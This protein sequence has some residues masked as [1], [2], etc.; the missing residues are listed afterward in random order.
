MNND[1][2]LI[3]EADLAL[4]QNICNDISDDTLRNK[5]VANVLAAKIAKKYFTEYDI[6]TESGLHNITQISK[7]IEISDIYLDDAYI[8]VRIYFENEIPKVPKSHFEQD[9]LPNA[10]MF[11][12]VDSE[13]SNATVTGFI[14]PDSIDTT[15]E[16]NEYYN[17][18]EDLLVSFYDIQGSINN[19]DVDVLDD[20]EIDIF[21]FLDNK[22]NETEEFFRNLTKSK[23][24]RIYLKDAANA[25]KILQQI[26]ISSAIETMPNVEVISENNT[27]S[28][29]ESDDIINLDNTFSDSFDSLEK[30]Q[31]TDLNFSTDIE[32]LEETLDSIDNFEPLNDDN[33]D[34]NDN[35]VDENYELTDVEDL[36]IE[37]DNY[38]LEMDDSIESN[39]AIDDID[40][41]NTDIDINA[42]IYEE[43]NFSTNTT[44]SISQIED[45]IEEEGVVTDDNLEDYTVIEI[46]DETEEYNQEPITEY[47]NNFEE[48]TEYVDIIEETEETELVKELEEIE[49]AVEPEEQEIAENISDI[50]NNEINELFG[51]QEDTIDYV[52]NEAYGT[53]IT[54]K[55]GNKALPLI[56]VLAVVGALGYYG[57]TKFVAPQ[58]TTANVLPDISGKLLAQK[59]ETKQEKVVPANKFE[60]M[61]LETIENVK[62]TKP[63]EEGIAISIPTIEENL[64]ASINVEN[65][66]VKWEVPSTYLSNAAASKYF[67][68]IGKI[69][70]LNLKT[71]MML[72]SKPPITNKI[73]LELE[74]N[75]KNNKF[76]VKQVSTS[77][78]EEIVDKLIVNTVKNA[79]ELNLKTNMSVFSNLLGNPV[80]IIRL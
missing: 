46:A 76:D 35:I 31:D 67:T 47:T 22:L 56:G 74:F 69:I 34:F 29:Y 43:E 33:N 6:D 10:Y 54:P 14:L 24:Y 37:D 68:K 42:D 36:S 55:K 12:K 40:E 66:N 64:G 5:T 51:E 19:Y 18:E 60:A 41:N 45:L 17:V 26:N 25:Q 13:L 58:T 4:A 79:L 72:L 39:I 65:L 20:I 8:D 16:A 27:N 53:E 30:N 15:L 1:N 71:E 75:K 7:F 78:G 77:S 73:M 48:N 59:S 50:N 61:P 44:P 70:Q 52:D 23:L 57:Y 80:L 3:E 38:S 21:N 49:E 62:V 9:I 28:T 63:T 2:F 32:S 11:I